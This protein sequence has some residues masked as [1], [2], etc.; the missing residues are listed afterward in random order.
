MVLAYK[1]AVY[2]QSLVCIPILIVYFASTCKMLLVV[3][4]WLLLQLMVTCSYAMNK[5]YVSN[6]QVCTV[7]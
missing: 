5:D 2:K 6:S 1:V 7:F 3:T 4:S